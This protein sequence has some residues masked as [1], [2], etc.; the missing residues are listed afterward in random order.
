MHMSHCHLA[1]VGMTAA[2]ADFAGRGHLVVQSAYAFAW[3]HPFFAALSVRILHLR[4]YRC[5][6]GSIA[7]LAA[8]PAVP[9][10]FS[11]VPLELRGHSSVFFLFVSLPPIV[12]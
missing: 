5:Y 4:H 6:L 2:F 9:R 7:D 10:Q 12:D 3:S 1:A 11:Y 8:K